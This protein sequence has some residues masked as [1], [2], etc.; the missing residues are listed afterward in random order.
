VHVV[1]PELF[2]LQRQAVAANLIELLLRAF[3]GAGNYRDTDAARFVAYAVPLVR[4]A[5]RTMA[6]LASAQQASLA[7]EQTGRSLAPPPVPDSAAVDLRGTPPAEVYAR[8]FNSVHAHVARTGDMTEA[9]G[10]GATRLREVAEGDMQLAYAHGSREAVTRLK[11]RYWRRT[12]IG[13]ENCA[14]CVLASTMKYGRGDLNPIHPGCDCEIVAVYNPANDP[15][16]DEAGVIE[17]AHAAAE[18]VAGKSDRGGRKV[19]Y[20]KIRTT[21]TQTHGELGEML[22]IPAYHFTDESE[23]L[24]A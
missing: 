16:K 8:P 19:D 7:A 18:E 10:R 14:L 1:L 24:S 21:I 20:R 2:S 17:A 22:A 13:P 6:T 5:Q 9:V 12:L 4:G 23:A 3:L 15:L 11:A